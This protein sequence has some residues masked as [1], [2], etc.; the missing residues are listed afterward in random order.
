MIDHNRVQWVFTDDGTPQTYSQP[1][2]LHRLA[3]TARHALFDVPK[4]FSMAVHGKDKDRSCTRHE[5]LDR[6][7]C[8]GPDRMFFSV[9]EGWKEKCGGEDS[10]RR[11]ECFVFDGEQFAVPPLEKSFEM[12]SVLPLSLL[13]NRD[14]SSLG[15]VLY[16]RTLRE[17]KDQYCW[18]E[19]P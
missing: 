15:R 8:C 19:R 13:L 3:S 6:G 10:D 9:G 1:S 11:G 17:T 5:V 2:V 7:F 14:L 4:F 16:I 12:R 18:L